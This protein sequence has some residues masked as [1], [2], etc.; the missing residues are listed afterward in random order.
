MT[1]RKRKLQLID[2][3]NKHEPPIKKQK[4]TTNTSTI[5]N[6]TDELTKTN[7]TNQTTINPLSNIID[8]NNNQS[9]SNNDN[10]TRQSL[11]TTATLIVDNNNN[12]CNNVFT[13]GVTSDNNTKDNESKTVRFSW[14]N[15]NSSFNNS[16][17]SDNNNIFNN[18][19]PNHSFANTSLNNT[20]STTPWKHYNTNSIVSWGNHTNPNLNGTND[21]F[22][23]NS[24]LNNNG[25]SFEGTF[26][27]DNNIN[28]D[29][30]NGVR[31]ES[32]SNTNDNHSTSVKS[33]LFSY[34]YEQLQFQQMYTAINDSQLIKLLNIT[35]YIQKDIAEYATGYLEKCHICKMNIICTPCS[36]DIFY[37][38]YEHDH[39]NA[40][41]INFKYCQDNDR[42]FCDKCMLLVTSVDCDC[43]NNLFYV[44]Y[45]NKCD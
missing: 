4:S 35:H 25:W 7:T 36:N 29:K 32:V 30:L 34:D 8:S 14:D 12:N 41:V 13:F 15:N 24:T 5:S 1:T 17:K 18:S 43:C 6:V 44:K 9:D 22:N 19:T 2:D 39:S 20:S 37:G 38:K 33:T 23:N 42:Y 3:E 28:N 21:T 45:G 26:S 31:L 27:C 11:N 16:N 10:K 40:N